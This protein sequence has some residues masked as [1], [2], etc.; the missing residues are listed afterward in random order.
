MI[1]SSITGALL[2]LWSGIR[3]CCSLFSAQYYKTMEKKASTQPALFHI[4]EHFS[5]PNGSFAEYFP[6][7]RCIQHPEYISTTG[8]LY[9]VHTIS[10]FSDFSVQLTVHVSVSCYKDA[11]HLDLHTESK[12]YRVYYSGTLWTSYHS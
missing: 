7:S 3:S 11:I 2:S 4:P 12:S 9:Y 6:T 5:V 1:S 8:G 10:P